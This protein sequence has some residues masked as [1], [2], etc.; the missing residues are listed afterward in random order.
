MLQVEPPSRKHLAERP[1]LPPLE[2]DHSCLDGFAM[3][4][5]TE[6]DW[7]GTPACFY[8]DCDRWDIMKVVIRGG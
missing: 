5:G 3:I 1:M 6:G 7:D 8:N 4:L 2:M